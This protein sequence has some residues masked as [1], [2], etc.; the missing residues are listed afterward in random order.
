M[1]EIPSRE[2]IAARFKAWPDEEM[3]WPELRLAKAY[4]EGA[5]AV[6]GEDEEVNHRDDFSMLLWLCTDG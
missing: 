5:V 3:D 6:V 1:T 2:E 4:L